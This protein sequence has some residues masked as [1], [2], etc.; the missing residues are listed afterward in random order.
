[1]VEWANMPLIT[2]G[3]TN[4]KFLLIVVIL[5]ILVGVIIAKNLYTKPDYS[6]EENKDCVFTCL[7]G[8]INK[9]SECK[10]LFGLRASCEGAECECINNKCTIKQPG[11]TV[12]ENADWQTYV[13]EDYEIET[14]YAGVWQTYRNEEYGFEI[15]YP[16]VW[17]NIEETEEWG[18]GAYFR[19]EPADPSYFVIGVNLVGD[20]PGLNRCISREEIEI[21]GIKTNK[22]NHWSYGSHALKLTPT[23]CKEDPQLTNIY[24]SIKKENNLYEFAFFCQEEEW[25]GA[26]G[27]AKCNHVYDQMLSSFRLVEEEKI[28]Q[29]VITQINSNSEFI[30]WFEEIRLSN[31][32]LEIKDFLMVDKKTYAWSDFTTSSVS[33]VKLNC[34]K[35]HVIAEDRTIYSPD[36]TKYLYFPCAIG[37]V[38]STLWLCNGGDGNMEAILTLGPSGGINNAFWIDDNYFI[39]LTYF[40]N[41]PEDCWASIHYWD[42]ITQEAVLYSVKGLS[43]WK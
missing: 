43:C 21:A 28:S 41:T 37:D 3:K 26:E 32:S 16:G 38:D 5:A 23:Q 39:V 8:C 18:F 9:D 31:A 35:E 30:G 34:D 36:K 14:E 25:Q 20:F 13:D 22:S 7:C 15:E 12:D 19:R 1:M 42:L 29:E 6:C 24:S 40:R 11:E 33:L 17:Q 10:N 27:R 2:Q 4:W